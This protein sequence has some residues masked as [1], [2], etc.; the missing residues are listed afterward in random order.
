M[1]AYIEGEPGQ[2]VV[3]SLLSNPT[4][5]C[6]A[7]T[8]NLCE[9][10]YQVARRSGIHTAKAAIASL[11][12][13]GVIERRD[14]GRQFWQLVGDHKARGGISLPD[15]FCITLAQKLGGDVVTSD[16]GEFDPLVPLGIDPITFIR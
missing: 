16:H 6:Y 15:C 12:M 10:Y 13:D 8:I 4:D 2:A 3:G 7:H 1:I 11:H 14:M 9:V 5:V